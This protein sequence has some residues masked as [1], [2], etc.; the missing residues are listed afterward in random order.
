MLTSDQRLSV[1]RNMTRGSVRGSRRLLSNH[2]NAG[3]R[4]NL[5]ETN[6]PGLGARTRP[7]RKREEPVKFVIAPLA[8]LAAAVAAGIVADRWLLPLETET[9]GS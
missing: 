5:R 9:L 4:R 2:R 6:L 8:P 3:Q 1:A 7:A